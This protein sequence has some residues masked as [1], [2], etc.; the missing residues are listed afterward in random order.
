M[1]L[2]VVSGF[3]PGQ[4]PG[5]SLLPGLPPGG[6]LL[7]GLPPGGSPLPGLPPGG[8][9]LSGLSPGVLSLDDGRRY[10]WKSLS[11]LHGRLPSP[12]TEIV[13]YQSM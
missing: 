9:L 3:L 10:R 5:G 8:S 12:I 7:S 4:P 2:Q 11:R 1:R 6:S 13:C